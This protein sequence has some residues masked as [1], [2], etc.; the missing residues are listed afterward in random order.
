LSDNSNNWLNW[1][2]MVGPCIF[3]ATF[4]QCTV[5]LVLRG[6]P[7]DKGKVSF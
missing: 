6:H 4:F 5:K 1:N 3:E 2:E 7:W